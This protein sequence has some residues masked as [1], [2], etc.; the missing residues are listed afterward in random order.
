MTKPPIRV[1]C[2]EDHAFLVDGL[3]A[4]FEIEADIKCVGHLESAE[5]L[6]AVAQELR[7]DIVLMDIEMPGPDPFETVVD[8]MRILPGSR[9]VFLSAYIRDHYL[10]AA[11]NAG[12]FG[13][14]SKS[15]ET[16][17]IIE[18]IRTVARR[19]VFVLSPKVK[20]RCTPTKRLKRGQVSPM[21]AKLDSLTPR[22]HEVLRMIGRGMTRTEIAE[23]LCRSVKTIDGH[24][25]KIMNKLD[26]HDRGELVRFTIREGLAEA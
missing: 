8:L 17:E 11:V 23:T 6:V 3:R 12:A 24:R 19:G 7:P 2:V 20:A 10:S 25:E 14:F 9:V 15:D 21:T 18:G 22:E 5:R 4:R 16:D 1:L 13:Y 26:I